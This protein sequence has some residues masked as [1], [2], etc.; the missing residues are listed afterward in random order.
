MHK[1]EVGISKV[2]FLGLFI[3]PVLV[4]HPGEATNTHKH[5]NKQLVSK[6]GY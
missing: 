6:L 1:Q 3:Y 4:Y 2:L 5:L